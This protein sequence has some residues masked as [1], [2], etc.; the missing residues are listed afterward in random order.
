MSPEKLGLARLE[1]D[2]E[3]YS[4]FGL[5][6]NVRSSDIGADVMLAL[7]KGEGMELVMPID[8]PVCISGNPKNSC[9]RVWS[10]LE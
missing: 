7:G 8:R 3:G 4:V 5:K 1:T 10:D 2:G 6:V 9:P